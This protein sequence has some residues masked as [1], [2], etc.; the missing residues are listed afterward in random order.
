MSRIGSWQ[1]QQQADG[2]QDGYA[3]QQCRF[4]GYDA[5]NITALR[6]AAFV[7]GHRARPDRKRREVSQHVVH[8]RN[9]QYGE[10]EQR[11]RVERVL[12]VRVA[13]VNPG[14]RVQKIV[15]FISSFR[16]GFVIVI[17]FERFGDLPR[18]RIGI[19]TRNQPDVTVKTVPA[20]PT[21]VVIQFFDI[22][23]GENGIV[24]QVRVSG[25]V[26]EY[27]GYPVR[28]APS[29]VTTCPTGS[30]FPK[31]SRAVLRDRKILPGSRSASDGTPDSTGIRKTLKNPVSA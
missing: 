6:S 4:A 26:F 17:F 5:E 13:D 8:R 21:E 28:V 10:C 7:H 11:Q 2:Q 25:Q 14:Q 29:L 23:Q 24:F 16:R 30:V 27:S 22:F 18:D 1:R 9:E 31:I 12:N 3:Q 15:D 20:A 19:G